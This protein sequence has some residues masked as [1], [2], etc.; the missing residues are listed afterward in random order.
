MTTV[1]GRGGSNRPDLAESMSWMTR[2]EMSKRI[3]ARRRLLAPAVS[4]LEARNHQ[5]RLDGIVS[6]MEAGA[7][8][9]SARRPGCGSIM[10][11]ADLSRSDLD[12]AGL[13]L[14]CAQ[15]GIEALV[16]V[17]EPRPPRARPSIKFGAERGY[18][19]RNRAGRI[20]ST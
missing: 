16:I 11:T 14:R 17:I 19:A 15:D 18:L 7:H 2:T 10:P 1:P 20:G 4:P 12:F 5:S 9:R 3:A 6:P 8:P 13:M